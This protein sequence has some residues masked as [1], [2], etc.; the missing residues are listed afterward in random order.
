MVAGLVAAADVAS[1]TVEVIA[2]QGFMEHAI[3]EGV[4]AGTAMTRRSSYMYG[5]LLPRNPEGSVGVGLGL[6][7]PRGAPSLIAP[8]REI[9]ADKETI[10]IDGVEMVFQLTRDTEAPVETN[11]YFPKFRAMWMAENVTATMHNIL[12]L[13]GALVR[14]ALSWSKS[15]NATIEEF[16]TEVDVRFQSHHWPKWGNDAVLADFKLQRDLYRFIHDRAVNL[17]NKGYVGEE[18]ADALKL[19]ETLERYWGGRG[20]Y[21]TLRHNVRAVYQRYMGWYD[22]NP[23]SLNALPPVEAAR[24]YVEYIGGEDA[25]LVRLREDVA[26]GEYR[27][28]A[29]ALKHLVFANPDNR[30]A[31]ELLAEVYRQLAYQ[32]ESGTWRS[33]Y[34][35]GAQEL[36]DGVPQLQ[37]KS[38]ASAETIVAMSPDMILDFL[39]V[40]L[41]AEKVAGQSYVIDFVFTDL[42]TTYSV[43]IGN[44]VLNYSTRPAPNPN[45]TV[46]LS[47]AGLAALLAGQEPDGGLSIEGD[48]AVVVNFLQS[49]EEVSPLFP[50]VE[51]RPSLTGSE[52][53]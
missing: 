49:I 26:N 10:A 43:E 21:G 16:G 7:T 39:A 6:A 53:R 50:I 52:G 48:K 24:K 28:A 44:S 42:E 9:V 37:V 18:I 35:Q 5:P 34:L 38:S 13:R 51:P 22:G 4:I 17:M 25:A 8:T 12:T 11:I 46:Q 23:S 27:W 32:S 1:G 33:I 20:Y 2:P 36:V 31:R 45:A 30:A 41:N 3:S 29:T 15:I 19:P 47:K 14:D 40:R